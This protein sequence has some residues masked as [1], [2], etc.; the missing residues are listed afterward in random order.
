MAA[1]V[2]E[3]PAAVVKATAAAFVA[4]YGGHAGHPVALRRAI[5]QDVAALARGD[6]GA[7]AWLR[8]HS[9]RVGEVG[10]DGSGTP[11]DLDTQADL[12]DL[13]AVAADT[14]LKAK[15][16]PRRAAPSRRGTI[17]T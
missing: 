17:K 16:G 10:C 5:W 15:A 11:A 8:S 3:T 6:V 14:E 12:A 1:M 2:N 13:E 7:R 9:D 4:T